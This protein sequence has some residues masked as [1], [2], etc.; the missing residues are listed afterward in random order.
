MRPMK[1]DFEHEIEVGAIDRKRKLRGGCYTSMG[2]ANGALSLCQT[3][4]GGNRGG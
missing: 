4:L 3:Q 1:H 2:G